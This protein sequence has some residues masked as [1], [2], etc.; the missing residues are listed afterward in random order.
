MDIDVIK[1]I[2]EYFQ[3]W[4]DFYHL[5]KL[6]WI[7]EFSFDYCVVEINHFSKTVV[8]PCVKCVHT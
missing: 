7:T 2:I 6:K 1:E 3:I 4:E 8:A 5:F